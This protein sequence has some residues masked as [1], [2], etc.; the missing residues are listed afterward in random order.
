MYTLPSIKLE[1][2][3][4]A[5]YL[6]PYEDLSGMKKYA[7]KN[8]QQCDH[9][10][11]IETINFQEFRNVGLLYCESMEAIMRGDGSEACRQVRARLPW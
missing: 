6:F 7:A 5:I 3:V 10:S 1:K 8:V 9:E 11:A 2:L 4:S